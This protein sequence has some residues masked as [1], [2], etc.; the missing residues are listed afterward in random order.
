[1][2]RPDDTQ[3]RLAAFEFLQGLKARHP[4]GLPRGAL[5]EGFAFE[6][7]RVILISQPGIFKPKILA[8]VPL[9]ITTSP[10]GPY[11]DEVGDDDLI[12]YRY[13]GTDPDHPDNVGLRL[14]MERGTPLIYFFGVQPGIYEAE[15]PVYIVGDDPERLTFTVS[16][17]PA[18]G[19]VGEA[20][21]AIGD[22]ARRY[23]TRQVR[24]RLHQKAF[25]YRV[26]RA[27]RERCAVCRLG[28]EVLLDAAHIL[29]DGDPR[30]LPIVPNGL[31]LCKLHHSAFDYYILGV[32]PDLVLEIRRD[33][34][35]EE[36][37]PMLVHGLQGF[38]GRRLI[39]PRT[40]SL[41]PSGEY[42]EERYE[43]FRT[44]G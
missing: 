43:R 21:A 30:S 8:D 38:Q 29:P 4:E 36:D 25:R 2:S 19:N 44:A 16:V 15:F 18:Q 5:T 6:G 35:D 14:A 9:T 37:G 34:L 28:H 41:R 26:L 20:G 17:A 12:R 33:V 40:P 11:D 32:R 13:R 1:M 10:A 7:R 3:V 42:L 24:Q 31:S 23:A 39:V 22:L 27:Y